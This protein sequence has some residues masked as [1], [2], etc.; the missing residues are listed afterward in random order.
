MVKDGISQMHSFWLDE[1]DSEG[2]LLAQLLEMVGTEN[3]ALFHFG[4]YER[5]FLSG[6]FERF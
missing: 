2:R 4:S 6:R 5:R 1:S 3:F